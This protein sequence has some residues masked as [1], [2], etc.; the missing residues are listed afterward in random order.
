MPYH[1]KL[2]GRLRKNEQT[3]VRITRVGIH[4]YP[5]VGFEGDRKHIAKCV[6]VDLGNETLGFI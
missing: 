4:L 1:Y 5:V 2:R 6:Q 3:F